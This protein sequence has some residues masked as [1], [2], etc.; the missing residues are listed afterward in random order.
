MGTAPANLYFWSLL[1]R[2]STTRPHKIEFD[3]LSQKHFAGFVPFGQGYL[4]YFLRIRVCTGKRARNSIHFIFSRKFQN[5]AH[6]PSCLSCLIRYQRA[7]NI[8]DQSQSRKVQN[9]ANTF[10]LIWVRTGKARK[11]VL[12]ISL[13]LRIFSEPCS[14]AK[15]LILFSGYNLQPVDSHTSKKKSTGKRQEN[16][17]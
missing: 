11:S 16:Q 10:L 4:W 17:Y 9:R 14:L 5:L 1:W 3:A 8:L 15:L 13:C 12:V 6:W 2:W 7:A